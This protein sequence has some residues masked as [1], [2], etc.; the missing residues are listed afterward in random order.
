MAI[1]PTAIIDRS[2]EIDSTAEI[3]AYVVIEGPVKIG[4]DTRIRP[5]AYVSGWTEIGQR[6]DIHP[7]AVVGHL[8][9]D[10][11]YNN[12]RSYCKIGND[13]IIRE[14]ATVHRGTQPESETVVGDEC[15]LLTCAHVGHN[16]RLGRGVKVYNYA[17]CS[18]HL[19]VGDFAILSGAALTHQFGRIGKYA[20]IAA[21]ARA[22]MDVPPFMT[23][24]GEATI[25]QVNV[26]GMRRAG[27]SS[28][29]IKEIREAYRILYRSGQPF[30]K[31]TAQVAEMVQTEAGRDLVAFISVDSKR[32]YC[33]GSTGHRP[34]SL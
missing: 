23:C 8:P 21:A 6:C 2:A 16:C 9:Q 25:V 12:E 11:H 29:S 22:G 33:K 20:F 14:S 18:G 27:Y 30:R 32:G 19:E 15:F 28:E 26:V 3:G 4:A 24:F 13:V 31:A 5:H 1:H 34:R 17:A 7:F 10:F